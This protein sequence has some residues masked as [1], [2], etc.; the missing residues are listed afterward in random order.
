[1]PDGSVSLRSTT[2]L[3]LN[4]QTN[5]TFQTI[6][7][8]ESVNVS[9]RVAW[10][11]PTSGF[12]VQAGNSVLVHYGNFA[13]TKGTTLLPGAQ[14]NLAYV[15]PSTLTYGNLGSTPFYSPS[16]DWEPLIYMANVQVLESATQPLGPLH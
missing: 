16:E 5:Y 6:P 1:M 12:S 11:G 9:V 13:P 14:V 8:A 15:T 2:S 7:I 3:T 10:D 4:G